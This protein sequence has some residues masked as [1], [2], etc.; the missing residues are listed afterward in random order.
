VTSIG[1]RYD[2]DGRCVAFVHPD[3]S[4][5]SYVFDPAGRLVAVSHPVA[6]RATF[7]RDASGR[8][9]AYQDPVQQRFWSFVD[10]HLARY[11]VARDGRSSVT[12]LARDGEGRIVSSAVDGVV[13]SFG[14][15]L[16]GQLVAAGDRSYAYDSCGRLVTESTAGSSV[17]TSRYDAVGALVSRVGDGTTTSFRHDRLGRRTSSETRALGVDQGLLSSVR[18]EWSGTDRLT[19]VVDEVTGARRSLRYDATGTL[20]SI[21]DEQ[22]VLDPT[23]GVPR[24]RQLGDRVV[25]GAGSP[26]AFIDGDREVEWLSPDHQGSLGGPFDPWGS[27]SPSSGGPG[28]DHLG[29][30][31]LGFGSLDLLGARVY[32]ASTRSFLSPDPLGPDV[33]GPTSSTPYHY[34][35]NDPINL[36]DPSGLHP[37][38]QDEYRQFREDE[39][40]ACLTG[41]AMVVAGGALSLVPGVGPIAGG[42]LIGMGFDMYSQNQWPPDAKELAVSGVIGGAAGGMGALGGKLG[43]QAGTMLFEEGST[44]LKPATAGV[45]AGFSSS[46]THELGSALAGRGFHPMNVVIGTATGGALAAA[47]GTA[48]KLRD[49]ISSAEPVVQLPPPPGAQ[50]ISPSDVRF[51]QSSIDVETTMDYIGSMRANGWKGEPIDVVEMKSEQLTAYDN[52]RVAAANEADIDLHA[53]VHAYDEPFP[54]ARLPGPKPAPATWGDAVDQRIASQKAL[55]RKTYPEGSPFTALSGGMRR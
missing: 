1:W 39:R 29:E 20:A 4:E 43:S 42:A 25:L 33:G 48:S 30:L 52:R 8:P 53:R 14:Y 49:W 18:Y 31:S 46:T 35:D 51:S 28:L 38:T 45:T 16:A 19:A 37:L 12:T 22:V 6:G 10:G 54:P 24:V 9:V 36:V 15:D 26:L 55:W 41:T 40:K 23:S 44:V 11:E 3:G 7:V 2:A 50:A 32:D 47:P 34:C 21:D 27:R 17:V 13:T 5:T